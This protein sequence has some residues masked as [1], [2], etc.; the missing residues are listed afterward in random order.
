MAALVKKFLNNS[1]LKILVM[2]ALLGLTISAFQTNTN[3]IQ[4]VFLGI[5]VVYTSSMMFSNFFHGVFYLMWLFIYEVV[6][7]MLV[8]QFESMLQLSLLATFIPLTI[9]IAFVN[10]LLMDKFN[11]K[12]KR[13]LITVLVSILIVLS[14]LLFTYLTKSVNSFI[15]IVIYFTIEIV[16]GVILYTNK[17]DLSK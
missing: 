7:A 10:E 13:L 9:S 16:F 14:L 5:F 1:F 17:Q 2:I 12:S 4:Y 6:V 11:V 15:Y 8:L 3:G